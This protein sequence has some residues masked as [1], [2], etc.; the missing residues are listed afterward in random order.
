MERY[1]IQRPRLQ[2]G[3]FQIQMINKRHIHVIKQKYVCI[4]CQRNGSVPSDMR[5]TETV[6]EDFRWLSTVNNGRGKK[7]NYCMSAKTEA[8]KN[9]PYGLLRPYPIYLGE[10]YETVRSYGSIGGYRGHGKSYTSKAYHADFGCHRFTLEQI[11]AH[12]FINHFK[13]KSPR[14]LLTGLDVLRDISKQKN[15]RY[16]TIKSWR[17]NLKPQTN[18]WVHEIINSDS[19]SVLF[20]DA[21]SKIEIF[22]LHKCW[23]DSGDKNCTCLKC[24]LNETVN[25]IKNK[26]DGIGENTVT[27]GIEVGYI[28]E[29]IT[30]NFK[31]EKARVTSVSETKEEVSMELYEQP[32]PMTLKMRGDH[33]RVLERVE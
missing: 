20:A 2:G 19:F 18:E 28:V 33:V 21:I 30:G 11:P 31:G 16:R 1:P 8:N 6:S 32:I 7:C 24:E 5:Y 13:N 26:L 27:S 23:L 25:Q 15:N 22:E 17:D 12:L 4:I 9:Y 14:R 29:I 10:S 3:P